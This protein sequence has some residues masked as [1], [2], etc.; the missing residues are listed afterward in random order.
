MKPWT[1]NP[2]IRTR[3]QKKW[4]KGIF[5]AHLVSDEPFLPLR[6][7]LKHPNT[8]ELTDEFEAVRQWITHL[9]GHSK[10]DGPK[11]YDLEWREINHRTLGR[12]RIPVAVVFKRL[13]AIFSYLGKSGDAEKFFN[14]Y[15]R[16]TAEFPELKVV[17]IEK[18]LDVI[19][20]DG[21]WTE[22]SAILSFLKQHPRPM[23]YLRQ[24]GIPGVDTKFIEQHKPW[25]TKLL[26]HLLPP[27]AVNELP[28]GAFSFEKRFGFLPKP[29]R[30]RF[31]ILDSSHYIMG[32]SDLEIPVDDFKKLSLQP[33]TV[34]IV[35]NDI[36]G[37][38]FPSFPYALV[39]FGLGY[40]L[41]ALSDVSWLKDKTIWYW[42]DID[43]HGF[44]MLDQIRHY[45]PHTRS[46][47]MDEETLLS[48]RLLWGSE[49]APTNREL[50]RL[51]PEE[52]RLYDDL[53][54]DRYAQSLRLEQECI[55]FSR[56]K[57]ALQKI[58]MLEQDIYQ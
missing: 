54:S 20:H 49:K 24:L 2:D 32:L 41:N 39:V 8:S 48:H 30:I 6:I 46:F 34:F 17:L 9:T 38:S 55:D 19:A 50:M 52:A 4:D 28:D 45:F 21:K 16:I 11:G 14:L 18:P 36:N 25:L 42:G 13:E 1:R 35:E 56:V 58:S 26:D 53:K 10:K 29:S 40:G 57:H 37:L 5:L 51:S 3:L 44:A 23:I 12:N 47:L 15:K 43:T 7:P 31:R 33:D 27:G 22:L